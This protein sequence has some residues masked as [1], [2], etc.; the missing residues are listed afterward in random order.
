MNRR[1]IVILTIAII[2]LLLV[3]FFINKKIKENVIN[4]ENNGIIDNAVEV[5]NDIIV[6]DLV[7]KSLLEID[8][9]FN[10]NPLSIGNEQDNIIDETGLNDTSPSNWINY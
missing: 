8:P 5:S 4:K 1:N 3:V 7:Q 10:P 6:T 2:I 9:T